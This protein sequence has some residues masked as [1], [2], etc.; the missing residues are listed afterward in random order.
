MV[1]KLPFCGE[2]RRFDGAEMAVGLWISAVGGAISG[3][4]MFDFFMIVRRMGRWEIC[5]FQFL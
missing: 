5:K 3:F 2:M 4:W 1:Q